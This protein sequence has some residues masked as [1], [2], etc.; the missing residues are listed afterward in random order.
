MSEW[1]NNKDTDN[2]SYEV[3]NDS[4]CSSTDADKLNESINSYYSTKSEEFEYL[5]DAAI[6]IAPLH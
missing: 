5:L 4:I 6:P 2:Y 3:D 1:E